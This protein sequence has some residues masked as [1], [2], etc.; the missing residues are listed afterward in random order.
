M[1]LSKISSI[2]YKFFGLNHQIMF[3]TLQKIGGRINGVFYETMYGHFYG[4]NKCGRNNEVA[5]LTKWVLLYI[6]KS[7]NEATESLEIIL[8]KE[9]MIT[10]DAH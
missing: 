6:E 4:P 7:S 8:A 9:L 5:V 3:T 10:K 2:S 1:K